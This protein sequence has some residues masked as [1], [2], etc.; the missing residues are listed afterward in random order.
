MPT[1][2][3]QQ[4]G[5]VP[6]YPTQLPTVLVYPTQLALGDTSGTMPPQPEQFPSGDPAP[7]PF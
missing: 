4:P 3:S 7:I 5:N 2:S 6:V 1:W